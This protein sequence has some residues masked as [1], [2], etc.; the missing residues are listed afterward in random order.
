MRES[1]GPSRLVAFLVVALLA[2]D[3]VALGTGLTEDGRGDDK[4]LTPEAPPT[5]PAPPPPPVPA[6]PV[7]ARS[8]VAAA[9]GKRIG[10]YDR[11]G[12][13]V[14]RSLPNPNQNGAPL[15]FL[16][17]EYHGDWLKVM[18]PVRPNGSTG[19]IRAG[20]VR[21]GQHSYRIVVQLRAHRITVFDGD[22]V[23]LSEPVGVGRSATRTRGGTYYIT[24]LLRPPGP[25]GPYGAYIYGLS[26]F[27]NELL[28]LAGDEGV[29]GIHGTNDPSSL[30]KD[31]DYGCIGMS[32]AAIT[33]LKDRLPLGTPV[34][35][36]A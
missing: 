3:V 35:I 22:D 10:I 5:P 30:G 4:A 26:G 28:G 17:Q 6:P 9:L 15:V 19:W 13:P 14:R 29:I 23:I 1:Q 11:P 24:E 31:V 25:N 12:S 18:L 34:D 16:V 8:M 2:V 27:S 32:N 7:P 36:H 33:R 21:L 20:D